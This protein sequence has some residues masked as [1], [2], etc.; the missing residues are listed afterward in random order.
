MTQNQDA[1]V[2]PHT[3]TV[4]GFDNLVIARSVLTSEQEFIPI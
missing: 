3:S 4:K 2:K 1:L